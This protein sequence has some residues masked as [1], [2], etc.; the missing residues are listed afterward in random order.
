MAK[1][2]GH[3]ARMLQLL[4][5]EIQVVTGLDDKY[6]TRAK[7]RCPLEQPQPALPEA[8]FGESY[9]SGVTTL[10]TPPALW[11]D[12]LCKWYH[13]F[14]CIICFDED[15]QNDAVADLGPCTTRSSMDSLGTLY[16]RSTSDSLASTMSTP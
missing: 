4:I 5:E 15:M 12:I 16:D 10:Y 6:R 3:I 14:G 8:G 9:M 11:L 7:N 1:V 2:S 13:G